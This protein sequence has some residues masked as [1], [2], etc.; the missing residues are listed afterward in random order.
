MHI[1]GMKQQAVGAKGKLFCGSKPAV[2][3]K[4]KL[5][6]EDEGVTDMNGNFSLQGS[7]RE[8]TTID[9]VFKIYHDC[10]DSIIP[11][12]RKVKFRIP[13]QYIF[14]GNTPKYSIDFG[15]LNLETIFVGEERDI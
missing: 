6:D 1:C 12:K 13:S 5:W 2:G 10:D 15:I 7:T 3:V 9:P 14:A 8:L 4:V 11:G